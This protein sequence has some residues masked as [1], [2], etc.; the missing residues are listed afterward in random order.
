[1]KNNIREE[2]LLSLHHRPLDLLIDCT[3]TKEDQFG[4]VLCN[5]SAKVNV[6]LLTK[7]IDDEEA[8][9]SSSV[10]VPCQCL[11]KEQIDELL[12]EFLCV[13]PRRSQGMKVSPCC[14]FLVVWES[15]NILRIS[16]LNQP[17]A[18]R[19]KVCT[20]FRVRCRARYQTLKPAGSPPNPGNQM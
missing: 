6:P 9:D 8:V 19:D 15:T 17:K 16:T 18:E 2:T 1:M 7:G 14:R 11:G 5:C 20:K 10:S 3:P 12:Q 13:G 4:D